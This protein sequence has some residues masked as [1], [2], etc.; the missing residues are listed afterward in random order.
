MTV[1]RFG[2]VSFQRQGRVGL[3]ELH[4]PPHNYF[5]AALLRHLGEA[6][7]AAADDG[8]CRA[9][10]LC[11]EG[12]SFCAGTDFTSRGDGAADDHTRAAR[13]Y[14]E[15]AKLF[16]V[17]T[18]VVAAIHGP[19]VGGGLGLA[20]VA[21]FRVASPEAR[22][23]AN[24]VRIGIHPGFAL[25]ATLPR[26]IGTQRASLLFYTGRRID[27]AQAIAWGLVDALAPAETLR[28]TAVALAAE[29]GEAAPLA[30]Q[31][32]RAT[33]RRDLQ[34]AVAAQLALELAE[35][36]RLRRTDDHREGVRAVS[37]RRPARF[38]GR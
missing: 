38:T 18:P 20:L 33:M 21:D 19:A 3:V 29:I 26:V 2:D 4:R 9:I 24:F 23:S 15:A 37:E 22:F 35:Q 16:A 13:L 10:V 6:F 12:R 11:A 31:S 8:E 27:G 7:S 34:A 25:T 14:D 5:D 36:T 32:T 17:R 28:E 1:E 30:V